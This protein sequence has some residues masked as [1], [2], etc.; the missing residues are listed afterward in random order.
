M[1]EAHKT[2][3]VANAAAR[4]LSGAAKFAAIYLSSGD[5]PAAAAIVRGS[6][7]RS[8]VLPDGTLALPATD[9]HGIVLVFK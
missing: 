7:L 3:F 6:G 8:V 1:R 2:A 5:L 9:A 4:E